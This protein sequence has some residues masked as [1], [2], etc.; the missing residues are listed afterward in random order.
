MKKTLALV[1]TM[2]MVMVPLA[3][4][5]GS[6]SSSAPAS[7]QSA[8]VSSAASPVA[9]SSTAPEATK[10]DFKAAILLP[11]SISDIGFSGPAYQGM[12]RLQDELGIEISYSEQVEVA[13]YET[14]FRGY[15]QEGYDLIIGQGNQFSEAANKVAEEF[16]DTWFAINS[17]SQGNGKNLAAAALNSHEVGFLVGSLCGLMTKSNRIASIAGSEI[18]PLIAVVDG[19]VAGAKYVNP[20]AVVENVYTGAGDAAKCKEA[21]IALL[22]SGCDILT[23]TADVG[24]IGAINACTEYGVYNVATSQDWAPQ[25]PKTVL[26]SVIVDNAAAV[27]ALGKMAYEGTLEAKVYPFGIKEEAV[28]MTGYG[29]LE[30]EVPAEVKAKMDEIFSDIKNGT[31]VPSDLIAK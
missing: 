1:L 2:L 30:A 4:C 29:E 3:A 21:A 16:P 25:A 10:K 6:A 13:D 24:S 12:V 9:P 20:D 15:A 26:T 14:T 7:S 11:G 5:G 31:L 17:G 18:P 22:D 8:A 23:Q 27:F 28:T 19:T